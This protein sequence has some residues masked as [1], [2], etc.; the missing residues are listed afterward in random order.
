MLT[1]RRFQPAVIAGVAALLLAAAPAVSAG[2]KK[3]RAVYAS[4]PVKVDGVLDDAVWR[5]APVYALKRSVNDNKSMLPLQEA[6]NVRFAWDETYLYMAVE[7]A[8][9][10]L[11]ALKEQD[12]EHHYKF[13]DVA[14]LFVKPGDK[15]GYWELYVTPAGYKTSFFI[16]A[17]G[18]LGLPDSPEVKETGLTVGARRQGTLNDATDK[19]TGWTAEMAMPVKD[20]ES[21]GAKFAPGQN[22]KVFTGRYNYAIGLE[23]GPELSMFPQ[24][25]VT[26]YH[27]IRRYAILDLQPPPKK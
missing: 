23:D 12:N 13:G 25:P 10:D 19:D 15:P 27:S 14:E 24:L 3:A 18:R 22:W 2:E 21:T 7:F 16:Q 1:K 6:G 20:L 17:R 26:N 9:S 11:V 8:D 4:T 5:N